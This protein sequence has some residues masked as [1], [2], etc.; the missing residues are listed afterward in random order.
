MGLKNNKLIY[1]CKKCQKRWL[2]PIN[3]LI[4]KSPIEMK[5][6]KVKMNKPIYLGMSIL[7]T[8][9]TLVYKFWHNYIKAKY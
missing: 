4:K 7:H 9:K 6:T 5:K 1:E 3:G 2:I 8:R